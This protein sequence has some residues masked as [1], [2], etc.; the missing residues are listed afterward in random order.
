MANAR[1]V[2]PQRRREI[3]DYDSRDTSTMID[4]RKRLAFADLGLELPRTP[5]TQVVSIRLPSAL[6]NELRAFGSARDIPYQA[7]I[8]LFL[9]ESL[10]RRK[11]SA[12]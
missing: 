9:A 10:Q 2:R 7:V 12:A 1:K 4:P 11:R 5:P 8:K 6:L 3:R